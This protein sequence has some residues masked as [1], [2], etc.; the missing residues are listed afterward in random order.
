MKGH[1]TLEGHPRHL[2]GQCPCSTYLEGEAW[3]LKT[4]TV[5]LFLSQRT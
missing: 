5:W 3:W 1:L 2:R 4:E